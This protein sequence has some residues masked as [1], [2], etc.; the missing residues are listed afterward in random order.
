M[1]IIILYTCKNINFLFA[2][3]YFSETVLFLTLLLSD[4]IP[5]SSSWNMRYFPKNIKSNIFYKSKTNCSLI[6][7]VEAMSE[8]WIL[9]DTI[10]IFIQVQR[11]QMRLR[12]IESM[13]EL[14]K[15]KDVIPSV[16]YYLLNGWQ[17]L[18]QVFTANFFPLKS[19]FLLEKSS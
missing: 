4:S 2:I 14:L 10:S 6:L 5:S 3:F 19:S 12:G 8:F 16:K 13:M 17:G 1:Y 18:I 11:S 7:H 9:L 15:T